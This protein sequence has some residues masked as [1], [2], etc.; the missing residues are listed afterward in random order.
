MKKLIQCSL[1]LVALSGC[2]KQSDTPTPVIT[3]GNPD[4]PVVTTP[5]SLVL[6]GTNVT[7]ED[8]KNL[9]YGTSPAQKYDLYLPSTRNTRNPV[10]V[11]LHGGA[12]QLNDKSVMTF[13]VDQLKA[14]QLNCAIVNADFRPTNLGGGITY[15]QEI[16]DIST[17][18]HKLASEAS[19]LGIGTKFYL[20]GMSSGGHLALLYASTANGDGLVSGV[21]AISPPV[22]LTDQ[23]IRDGVIGEEVT[24]AIG[25]SF[26]EAPA[27]YRLASPAFQ[28]N[29]QSPPCI[30][31]NGGKDAIVTAHQANLAK[32]AIAALS[33]SSE[34]Y[35]Y[36]DQTHEWSV[37]SETLDKMI[38]FAEK[39]L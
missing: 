1:L 12:W 19:G 36:P 38:T 21:G 11:I 33:A 26:A 32:T 31:F 4:V 6:R 5:T 30:L 24:V 39:H 22:D 3:P 18:L 23:G 2:I 16:E 34:Y 15:R 37:W 9:A 10:I 7:Y 20:I 28:Y 25:K 29:S 27:Q 8:R 35:F 17:L 14:K 13:A